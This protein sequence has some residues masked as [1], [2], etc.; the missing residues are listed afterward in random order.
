MKKTIL[1]VDDN[2]AN[3]YVLKSLLESEGMK[4]ITAENGQ[5][6]LDE[7]HAFPPDLIISDILMPVMDG[8]TLCRQWKSDER[9]K[10]I[11]FIFYTATYTESKDEKFALS[12]GADRFLVKP[13]EPEALIS[14]LSEFLSDKYVGKSAQ[15]KPLGEEMEFFRTHN[16]ILFSKL[17]KKMSDLQI[18]NEQLKIME[19]RYRLSFENVSD[20]IYIIEAN[21]NILSMSP[22]AEKLL[23]YSV[24]DFIGRSVMDLKV[25]FT[26]ESFERAVANSMIILKGKELL[27]EVYEFVAKDGTIKIG[28]V[29]GSPI[30]RDGQVTGFVSIARDI[31]DRRRIE[32]ELRHSEEK[33]RMLF[34]NADEAILVIQNSMMIYVN[35]AVIAL[36]EYPEDILLSRPFT[37][38]IY[39][40]DRS[41]VS[42]NYQKRI[43]GEDA[44]LRYTFRVETKSGKV[45]WV[46]IHVS[47]IEWQ[48]RPASLNFLNDITERKNTQDALRENEDKYRGILEDMNDMYYELDLKGNMTFFNKAL[49]T[50]T[51]RS[52]SEMQGKN[53]RDYMSP[54]SSEYAL[55]IFGKIYK[56]GKPK[57]FV[58]EIFTKNGEIKYFESQAGLLLDKNNQPVGFRGIARDITD[59][60][61]MEDALR[62]SEEKYRTILEQ[63]N[64]GYFEVDLAGNYTFVTEVSARLLEYSTDELIGKNSLSFMTKETV[65]LV[66]KAFANIY[67]SG[68]PERNIV[69]EALHKSGATGIGEITGFPIKNEKGDIVGFRGVARDITD[70]K[71]T[72]DERDTL[73][74]RLRKALGAIIQA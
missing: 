33:Y 43:A 55:Q 41:V 25:I 58:N 7:A 44:P 23:G 14:M 49:L 37:D 26:P 34:D 63:M 72:Q 28:E 22:S 48:G 18:A 31:T 13:Q 17:E 39:H 12:L 57:M 6:A 51:G 61:K 21:L 35:P 53:F 42:E 15:L 2:P 4:V 30:M 59:R 19:E 45:K 65:P 74:S 73:L 3:L 36:T 69:F 24:K 60:R 64:D 5:T 1:I 8:Y 68:K 32:D 11:P 66:Q 27:G 40:K 54:K 38:F 50:L 10:G 70:R 20:V 29:S 62:Q 56:T 9:L 71:K 67:K 47:L 46:E 52:P 16:E